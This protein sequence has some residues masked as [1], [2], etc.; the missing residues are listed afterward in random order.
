MPSP[1]ILLENHICNAARA[2]VTDYAKEL[3]ED[4][5][6]L[7]LIEMNAEISVEQLKRELKTLLSF[8]N[9]L[10]ASS[11]KTLLDLFDALD[12]E[13]IAYRFIDPESREEA[14]Q[15][16]QMLKLAG[17]KEEFDL[18]QKKREQSIC[19]RD[20]I[21]AKIIMEEA[22]NHDG[23]VIALTGFLHHH[24]VEL[25]QQDKRQDYRYILF[26][27][28]R[29]IDN[30]KQDKTLTGVG[31]SDWENL[32]NPSIRQRLYHNADVSLIEYHQKPSYQMIKTLYDFNH[33]HPIQELPTIARYFSETLQGDYEFS[34]NRHL[35]V[36]ASKKIKSDAEF[37]RELLLLNRQFP[38][39][40]FFYREAN[41]KRMIGIPGLNLPENSQLLSE[42]YIKAGVMSSK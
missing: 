16:N 20:I 6:N 30:F 34:I 23:G 38:K 4:G 36:S 18:I 3:K 32:Q 37:A 29:E 22:Q 40:S 35:I 42:G 2:F 7:M 19:Q 41:G 13:G 33:Q 21:M 5:Y 9:P 26:N 14:N 10:I 12:R 27:N 31:L 11:F 8:N 28:A 15:F 24:L 1:L 39:L 17:N 25:L